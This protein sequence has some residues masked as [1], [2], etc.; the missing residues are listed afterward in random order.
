MFIFTPFILAL[1]HS[2]QL[3]PALKEN[4]SMISQDLSYYLWLIL[5]AILF[6]AVVSVIMTLIQVPSS[7]YM[8]GSV[9]SIVYSTLHTL[10]LTFFLMTFFVSIFKN[11][12]KK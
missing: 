8:R 7:L 9:I 1:G 3:L 10:I 5:S 4:I 2:Q 12:L 11:I 6:C